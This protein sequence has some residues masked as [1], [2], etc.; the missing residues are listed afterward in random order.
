MQPSTVRTSQDSGRNS[1]VEYLRIFSMLLIIAF[2]ARNMGYHSNAA[3][4]SVYLWGQIIGSW[5][6]LGVDLFLITSAWFLVDKKFQCRKMISIIIQTISWILIFSV[7][8][9]FYDFYKTKSFSTALLNYGKWFVNSGINDPL[10]SKCY[11]Y[12]T[13]YVFML[14][15]SPLMN[16]LIYTSCRAD[17]YKILLLFSFI[18]IFSQFNTSVSGD[19]IYFCYVYI[20]IGTA[21]KY[22]LPLI[23][24]IATPSCFFLFSFVIIVVRASN[25]Y[26]TSNI[27]LNL[28]RMVFNHLLGEIGRHSIAMLIDA[29]MIFFWVIKL[30]PTTNNTINKLASHTLGVYLF[31]ENHIASSPNVVMYI[32][33]KLTAYG[34]ITSTI[35]FPIQYIF[36]ILL[37][38]FMGIGCEF[39]RFT[40]FHKPLMSFLDKQFSKKYQL[41]DA[42]FEGIKQNQC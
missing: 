37:V 25:Y 38:Y 9:V 12:V 10:W 19:I 31:H 22:G 34:F 8:S 1:N 13:S 23:N 11:W 7:L 21:K 42:W 28:I 18:P 41:I 4:F 30:K 40:I 29:G 24:Q 5:G 33:K 27:P 20:L 39:L 6:I 26:S 16:K 36:S 35:V 14:I 32:F 15:I 17:L 2:H 3:P